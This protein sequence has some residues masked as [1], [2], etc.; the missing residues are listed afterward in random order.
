MLKR[1]RFVS[2]AGNL[3]DRPLGREF[4]RRW[5]QHPNRET[6]RRSR[7][8]DDEARWYRF[9]IADESAGFG[10]GV[11]K[12]DGLINGPRQTPAS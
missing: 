10:D 7:G 2:V 9:A 12:V 1:G 6:Q 8:S 3:G 5:E 11:H 4:S